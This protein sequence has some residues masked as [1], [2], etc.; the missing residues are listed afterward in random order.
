[1]KNE[2][3]ESIVEL[4]LGDYV[5]L[6]EFVE[7]AIALRESLKEPRTLINLSLKSVQAT[8]SFDDVL[9]KLNNK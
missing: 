9:D 6:K 2:E 1:M 5:P 4:L 7:T 8:K 3:I